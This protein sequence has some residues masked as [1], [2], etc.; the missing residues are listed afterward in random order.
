[1][2]T[3]SKITLLAKRTFD[4]W[5]C[6]LL[7]PGLIPLFLVI[8]ILVKLDGGTIFFLSPRAGQRRKLFQAYKFRSMI[9]EADKY[10]DKSGRPT[11]NRVTWVGKWLRRF[12]LDELPQVI[13]VIKG[14]MSWVGPRPI[15]PLDAE[16]IDEKFLPRFDVLPGLTGLAQVNGRNQLPWSKRFELDVKYVSELSL[17]NDLKIVIK[18]F[19]TV[20]TGAGM[21]MDRNPQQARK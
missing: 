3:P 17:W 12:S 20:L 19:K 18:T 14:E 2:Q 13:N 5:L 15:L 11:K 7:L 9:V 8:G 4:L 21:S 6:V 10:L 16:R 1:M